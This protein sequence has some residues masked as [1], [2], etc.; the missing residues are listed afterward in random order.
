MRLGTVRVL[1]VLVWAVASLC[2]QIRILSPG[3]D[4]VLYPGR[5]VR[6]EWEHS[7]LL[8]TDVLYSTNQGQSWHA[9][10]TA[11]PTRSIE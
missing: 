3:Q 11:L 4:Q 1:F 6:I 8:L 10:G 9:I 5:L 2:A 7:T